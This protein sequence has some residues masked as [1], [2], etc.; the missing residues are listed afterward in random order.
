[1]MIPRDILAELEGVSQRLLEIKEAVE[2][3]EYEPRTER[4]DSA[5]LDIVDQAA[6]LVCILSGWQFANLPREKQKAGL[7]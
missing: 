4:A 7:L 6:E 3:D 1:M 5:L 2:N